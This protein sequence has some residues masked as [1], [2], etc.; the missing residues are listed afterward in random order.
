MDHFAKFNIFTRLHYPI[1]AIGLIIDFVVVVLLLTFVRLLYSIPLYFATPTLRRVGN[2]VIFTLVF[3]GIFSF[4]TEQCVGIKLSNDRVSFYFPFPQTAR[5]ELR[6]A[7]P[8]PSISKTALVTILK[9]PDSSYKFVPVYN[10]D[11]EGLVALNKLD[12]ALTRK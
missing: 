9:L 4:R 2:Y 1:T 8:S 10:F 11:S 7:L 6:T 3:A 5:D 12:D